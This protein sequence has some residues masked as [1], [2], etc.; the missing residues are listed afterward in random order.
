MKNQEKRNSKDGVGEDADLEY[1]SIRKFIENE[2]FL[3]LILARDTT[4]QVTTLQRINRFRYLV[5]TGN[6]NGIIGY[7]KGKG[8][9]FEE[10]LVNAFRDVKRNLIAIPT[11]PFFTLPAQ[12]DSKHNGLKLTLW[13]RDN[14]NAWGSPT[15]ALMLQLAGI[16]HFS[17][18][19]VARNPN[20]YCLVYAFFKAVTKNMTPKEVSEILGHK[21]YHQYFGSRKYSNYPD[22]TV[23]ML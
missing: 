11:D 20:M 15:M 7:G 13:P 22:S 9:D 16:T 21:I 12:I 4:T 14:M 5:F 2:D 23:R 6:A 3:T 8:L 10:A 19:I 18:K 17:F 1:K